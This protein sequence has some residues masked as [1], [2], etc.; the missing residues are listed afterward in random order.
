MTRESKYELMY[1]LQGHY[2]KWEDLTE[3]TDRKEVLQDIKDYRANETGAFRIIHRKV[4]KSGAGKD[5]PI[6]YKIMKYKQKGQP[7][8]VRGMSNLTEAEAQAYCSRADTHGNGW[9]CGYT[10]VQ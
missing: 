7:T 1:V 3:S 10:N 5:T 4:L 8:A 9:F 6:R 2:G